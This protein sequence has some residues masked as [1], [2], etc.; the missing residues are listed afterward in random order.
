[1]IELKLNKES[2][3]SFEINIEG[4]NEKPRVRLMLEM[5]NKMKLAIEG[6]I[7][8]GQAKVVVPSLMDL[9]EKLSGENVKGSLEVIVDNNFF[10][11]WEEYFSLKAPITV[12]AEST[13]VEN[14]KTP[15]IKISV[16]SNKIKE[17]KE[18][19]K[20]QK[21]FRIPKTNVLLEAGDVFEVLSEN[22]EGFDTAIQLQEGFT[23]PG[24]KNTI[25]KYNRIKIMGE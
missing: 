2:E 9:K 6:T 24:T 23:I 12:Q 21:D 10:I 14:N 25:S 22:D 1:M 13:K 4:S 11:P 5:D 7:L 17:T 19:I 15:E 8:E 3:L 18:I 16:K 20:L